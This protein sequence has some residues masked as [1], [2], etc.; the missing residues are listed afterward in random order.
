VTGVVA[1]ASPLI[2][3]QQI[4][5]LPL[6][7]ALFT[8][9]IV[10]PAVAR[11]IARSVSPQPW[12]IE[13]H[14]T[15]P[16]VPEVLHASLGAGESEAISLA[17]ELRADRLVVDEKA[18]RHLAQGLG[19][20]VIGTLGVL[21]AAKRRRLITAVRPLVEALLEKKFWISPQLVEHGD[22]HRWSRPF[23]HQREWRWPN[24]RRH[25]NADGA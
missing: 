6:L 22:V 17:L 2:A 12:I 16:P 1:D 13:R 7:Q 10:P 20:T 11:E 4:G 8:S 25:S 9:L 5:Q 21:L 14:L 24:P 19:L 23:R 3:F 15:R 18:A